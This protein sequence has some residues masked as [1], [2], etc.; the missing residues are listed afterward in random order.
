MLDPTVIRAL[1][2]DLDDTLWDIWPTI[3]RAEQLLHDWLRRHHPA[4]PARYRPHQ[5]RELCRLIAE[6]QPEI[7]HDR[8]LLR[9][10]ALR[11]AADALAL[12]AF[13][14]HTAFEVFHQAR[15]EVEFFSDALPSLSRLA[16][17]YPLVALSNGNADLRLVGIDHLFTVALN[18]A[19]AGTAKPDPAMYRAACRA[20]DL[21]PAQ[22][23]HIGDDPELD[24]IGAARAGL[25][26][27]WLNR[28]GRRWPGGPRPT[29]EVRNLIQL[30]Q[31]LGMTAS[32]AG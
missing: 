20:L 21:A 9:K 28:G 22:L 8:S 26:T 31:V 4:I 2:F 12:E 3:A 13:C 15:N 32:R 16:E 25:P 14:E 18:P 30:E 29:L 7:A 17:R 6:Q 24:V 23:L 5:L 11:H 1:S 19:S 27:V 10:A